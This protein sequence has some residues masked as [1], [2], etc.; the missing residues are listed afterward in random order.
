M[1]FMFN[2]L[3]DEITSLCREK[4]TSSKCTNF[5]INSASNYIRKAHF[6]IYRI[7]LSLEGYDRRGYQ[8]VSCHKI[9]SVECELYMVFVVD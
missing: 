3:K 2:A 7:F 4:G 9:K 5:L 8:Y 1:C 6:D